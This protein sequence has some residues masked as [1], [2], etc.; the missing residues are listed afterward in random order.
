MFHLDDKQPRE[1][2]VTLVSMFKLRG[3]GRVRERRGETIGVTITL[4]AGSAGRSVPFQFALPA[5]MTP[6]LRTVSHELDW[7]LAFTSG[8]FFGKKLELAIPLEIVD[9]SAMATTEQ[10]TVAPRLADEQVAAAFARFAAASWHVDDPDD[11]RP[12]A[13]PSITREAGDHELSVAYSYRGKDGTFLV[14]RIAHPSLGLGLTVIPS[15]SLRHVFFEDVEVDIT[16][17]DRAHHVNARSPAQTVPLLRT[18]V[19]ALLASSGLGQLVRWSDDALVFERAVASVGEAEL[20]ELATALQQVATVIAAAQRDLAPPPELTV[21]LDG[22]RELARWLHGVFTVGD[23][24]IDGRLGNVSVELGLEWDDHGRPSTVRASVGDPE[25]ASL[26]TRAIALSLARPAA[27]V[28]AVSVP[29]G[30]VDQLT[31]WPPEI[32]E[33]RVAEGVAS[34]SWRLPGGEA[35]VVEARRVRE[36]VEALRAV[37]ATLDPGAGPYR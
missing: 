16:G 1:V 17:W 3:R 30:L 25:H 26:A 31:Q 18:V 37:L 13:G 12:G 19:P 2:D 27:D 21:D 11:E 15:S 35:P 9:A 4:P 29:E 32:V 10:L 6:S 22:W 36:L 23:L 7:W 28:L 24:S 8:S 5:T 20:S 33:L 34:A 14:G